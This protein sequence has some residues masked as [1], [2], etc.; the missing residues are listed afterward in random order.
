MRVGQEVLSVKSV[1][2]LVDKEK[3]ARGDMAPMLR[4]REACCSIKFQ[5]REWGQLWGRKINYINLTFNIIYLCVKCGG[6]TGIRTL[7]TLSR[8]SVF[9]TGAFDHSATPPTGISYTLLSDSKSK[10][11]TK[12][13]PSGRQAFN[14]GNMRLD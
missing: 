6:G 14:I 13:Y 4:A 7:G 1:L 9:K 11:Q 3:C 5:S 2:S 10:N 8:P 12:I